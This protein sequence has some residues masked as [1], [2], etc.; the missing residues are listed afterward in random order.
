MEDMR[1]MKQVREGRVVEDALARQNMKTVTVE[2]QRRVL[3]PEVKKYVRR[4]KRFL[5]HDER[6]EC[7]IGDKVEIALGR[8]LS[9]RKRWRV[10]RVVE[11]AQ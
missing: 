11:K 10:T 4:F 6:N 3:H 8:P 7:R 2:I 1:G 9:K 5:A